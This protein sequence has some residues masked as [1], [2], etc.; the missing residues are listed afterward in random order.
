MSASVHEAAAHLQAE[1]AAPAGRINTLAYKTDRESV[2]RVLVDP[3]YW[4]SLG[5]MP[6]VFEGYKVT[7]ERRGDAR[8]GSE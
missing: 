8:G 5:P 4:Y 1:L 3:D 6:A 2:I 7:V